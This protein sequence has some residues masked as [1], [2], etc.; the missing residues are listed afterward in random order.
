M[1]EYYECTICENLIEKELYWCMR[2]D[3]TA[4]TLQPHCKKCYLKQSE[5]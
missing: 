3:G 2:F 5:D 4:N 1:K